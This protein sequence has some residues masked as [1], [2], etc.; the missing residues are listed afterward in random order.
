[1]VRNR[2]GQVSTDKRRVETSSAA[3][4]I[5]SE[6]VESPLSGN[7]P[8]E[9]PGASIGIA[10]QS[11]DA[12]RFPKADAGRLPKVML[13][14]HSG[15]AKCSDSEPAGCSGFSIANTAPA[16]GGVRS[17][18]WTCRLW[19]AFTAM[20]SDYRHSR[21]AVRCGGVAVMAPDSV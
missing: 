3:T 11:I 2:S 10:N 5:G 14:F 9:K 1:M 4:D 21:R 12:P 15:H 7:L 13:M 17:P 18:T 20:D 8:V 19:V 6:D 16:A